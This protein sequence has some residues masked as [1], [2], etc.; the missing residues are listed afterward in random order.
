M[1]KTPREVANWKRQK[2]QITT[3]LSTF[4]WLQ[5]EQIQVYLLVI[6]LKLEEHMSNWQKFTY[7]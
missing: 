5:G 1:Q 6:A 3:Y 2:H 7:L 4:F